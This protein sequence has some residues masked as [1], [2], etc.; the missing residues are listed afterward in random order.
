MRPPH[1]MDGVY[2]DST[3]VIYLPWTDGYAV[4]YSCENSNG[5]VTYIYLNASQDSDGGKPNVF[6]YEGPH[7]DPALDTPSHHYDIE[8]V[9]T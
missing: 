8:W 9:T 7:G 6:V 4:G 3:Q 2:D 1:S 5:D